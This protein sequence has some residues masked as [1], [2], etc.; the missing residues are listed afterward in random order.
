M[1]AQDVFS[2]LIVLLLGFG[3]VF[4]AERLFTQRERSILWLSFA[5]HVVAALSMVWVTIDILGGGDMR[6]YHFFG[7][8]LAQAARQD[9]WGVTPDLLRVVFQ[10]ANVPLP[11][12]I[13]GI[14]SAT[15]SMYSLCALVFLLV[16]DSLYAACMFMAIASFLARLLIYS[17]LRQNVDERHWRSVGIACLL[18]PSVSFWCSGLMKEAFAFC[19]LGALF[20]GANALLQRR[21]RLLA[22]PLLVSGV[23]LVGV[24]KPYVL[25]P[26]GIGIGAWVFFIATR[27]NPLRSLWALP[28]AAAVALVAVLAVGEIFPRYS[29]MQLPDETTQ[30]QD[31]FSQRTGGDSKISLGGGSETLAE[32]RGFA[33]QLVYAPLA[34]VTALFRPSLLDV[35]NAQMFVNSLEVSALTVMFLLV[36][37]RKRWRD[38]FAALYAQP[39]LAFCVLFVV[40]MSLGVGL[41]T[42]N[43]GSLSRYRTPMMPFFAVALALGM[44]RAEAVVQQLPTAL[45]KFKRRQPG[46][47]HAPAAH[48]V[49]EVARVVPF[50]R[51]IDP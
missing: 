23:L 13:H 29:F 12:P 22:L 9:F 48:P 21:G 18:L 7:A 19:G 1:Q 34:I 30:L 33:G 38:F 11:I 8:R 17:A 35:K 42:P 25:M 44:R 3:L 4:A 37:A 5:S 24:V 47:Q 41:A 45:A 28:V 27:G 31:V 46:H 49:H 20:W 15:G 50:P 26:A 39:V 16:G 14:G 51:S 2:T 36:L 6:N 10:T 43:L 40:V 32:D